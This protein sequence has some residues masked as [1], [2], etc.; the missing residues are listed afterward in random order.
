M[1]SHPPAYA[2]PFWIDRQHAPRLYRLVHVGD[3]NV[4]GLRVS[5]LGPGHLVPVFVPLLTPGASVTVTVVG[6]DL[7]LGTVA[8]VSWLRPDGEEYLW[9]FSF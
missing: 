3:E 5:L 1:S 9:R 6:V 7:S 4:R 8:V 2:V